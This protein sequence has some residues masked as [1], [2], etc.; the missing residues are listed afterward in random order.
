MPT[1]TVPTDGRPQFS[2]LDLALSN[3]VFGRPSLADVRQIG[4][5]RFILPNAWPA[6]RASGGGFSSAV[7][8]TQAAPETKPRTA[9]SALWPN[10]PARA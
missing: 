10:L 1:M 9:A 7:A 3:Y 8:S 4:P 5:D 6:P 2:F